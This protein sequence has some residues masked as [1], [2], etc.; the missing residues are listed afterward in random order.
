MR[1]QKVYVDLTLYDENMKTIFS[2]QHTNAEQAMQQAQK[3]LNK[4]IRG[5]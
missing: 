1:K 4:K 3:I 2:R 5:I